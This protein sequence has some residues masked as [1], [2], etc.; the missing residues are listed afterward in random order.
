MPYICTLKQLEL[1]NS[2]GFTVCRYGHNPPRFESKMSRLWLPGCSDR[3]L[4]QLVG[5]RNPLFIIAIRTRS[6]YGQMINLIVG[7]RGKHWIYK[8]LP[9]A[10]VHIT[11]EAY[12]VVEDF[13]TN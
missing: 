4:S 10:S 2:S 11:G 5:F 7:S 13:G 8:V 6:P 3:F 9:F 1:R 12:Y